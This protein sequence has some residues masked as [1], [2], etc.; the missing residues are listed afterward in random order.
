MSAPPVSRA[1]LRQEALDFIWGQYRL[2]DNTSVRLRAS[3]T[4]WRRL[5]LALGV[6]GALAA[7]LSTQPFVGRLA[8]PGATWAGYVPG[9][10]GV[11]SAILLG[12][13]A[14][15]SQ[16]VLSPKD[17]EQWVRVRAAAEAL[18]REAYLLAAGAPPYDADISLATAKDINKSLEDV[19]SVPPDEIEGGEEPP[20][21]PMTVETYISSRL[22]DQMN[23]YRR[24]AGDHKATLRLIGGFTFGLGA[25]AVVLGAVS[26]SLTAPWVAV[27]TTIIATLAAYL[28]AGRFQYMVIS[29]LATARR[30]EALRAD[31]KISGK[32]DA[33]T[34]ARNQLI[35]ECEGILS[36]ENKAWMTE[37]NR[38]DET[39][40][41]TVAGHLSQ[42]AN[43]G[44]GADVAAGKGT[45]A[46]VEV[47]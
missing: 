31:W 42:G 3:L 17:E 24:W 35:L 1:K 45:G 34:D 25:L 47:K 2:W 10:L 14:F 22:E 5:V 37:L 4:F 23:W 32:S 12:L 20:A 44:I 13:A 18:K 36:A 27:I 43:G 15:F 40:A 30:L 6:V 28:Y 11:L 16:K 38:R 41:S 21:C 19:E 9:G 29:Y 26:S 46:G 7:T 39:A 33:D 8:D